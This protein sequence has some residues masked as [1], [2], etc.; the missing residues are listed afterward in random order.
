MYGSQR[1]YGELAELTD[2]DICQIAD[3]SDQQ[4]QRLSYSRTRT[5]KRRSR[6]KRRKEERE[7]EGKEEEKEEKQKKEEDD[8]VEQQRQPRVP[9]IA[10]AWVKYKNIRRSYLLAGGH[11]PESTAMLL[12]AAATPVVIVFTWNASEQFL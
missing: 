6:R 9:D 3:A 2:D 1:C 12:M 10:V 8:D 11:C 4:L 7:R 5:S